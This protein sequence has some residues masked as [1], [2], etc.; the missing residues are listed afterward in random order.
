[1]TD[2]TAALEFGWE[3]WVSLPGLGLPALKAKTDT[4]ARTSALHAFAI[5][6]FGSVSRPKVR[7][8][9]QPIPDRP[10]IEVFCSADLV[11]RREVTSSNGEAELRYVVRTPV[12]VSGRS[13]DIE[14][15]LTDRGSMSYRM[16][17][18]RTAL[19]D[20][21]VV[22]PEASFLQPRLDY[23]VY[24]ELSKVPPKKRA[25][26]VAILTRE[27]DNYSSRRLIEAG[28][29]RDHVVEPIDTLR[30]YMNINAH[31]PEV[32][33]DGRALPRYDAIIPRI[34]A[35]I[36]SYGLAV[37]RQFETL[38]AHCLNSS[39]GIGASRDK[40]FAHQ[41]L[42]RYSIRMPTTAF[43]S[44]P[45]DSANLINLVGS[46]PIIV[47]LLESSQGKGVVLAEN[48]KA[49]QS[50]VSAFRNLKADFLVQEFVKEA[51]GEDIRIIVIGGKFAAAMRRTAGEGDFRA[52]LHQGGAATTVKTTKE[53]R[54]TAVRA[55]RALGLGFAGVDLL[56]SESGPKVLEVNSS[57]G[58]EGVEK[59]SDKDIAGLVFD[60]LERRVR[61]LVRRS[62][63]AP[64]PKTASA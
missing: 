34:G 30:C 58:L 51:A 8:G 5:E 62:R 24:D 21:A 25:L 37:V 41:L 23:S 40:L 13:W 54:D 42:A 49:A 17:I 53:E 44:S 45:K 57:P 38:G 59:V 3:E 36:T 64:S 60:H 4:G 10:E 22:K 9:V 26:R 7:F 52:N 1:M 19:A 2:E 18:G 50:V 46:A 35:G 32:H 61:P 56:R 20:N 14:M 6:P 15:T 16:L 11:D 27:P 28:E 48:A 43:A 39:T 63:R 33:Y 12:S 29:A 55:A 31:A 47:K